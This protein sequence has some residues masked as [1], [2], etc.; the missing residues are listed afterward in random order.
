VPS[1]AFHRTIRGITCIVVDA[2]TF[3]GAEGT[4]LFNQFEADGIPF[5]ALLNPMEETVGTL[6]W[7]RDFFEFKSWLNTIKP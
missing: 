6:K 7:G 3:S 2:T 1:I 4:A 5:F